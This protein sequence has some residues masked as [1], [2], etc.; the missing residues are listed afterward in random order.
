M[1]FTYFPFSCVK[2]I[3]C[4]QNVKIA[5][6]NK[7]TIM[8]FPYFKRTLTPWPRLESSA[9][10]SD[11]A[12]GRG[13]KEQSSH[14]KQCLP[15]GQA[16]CQAHFTSPLEYSWR[17]CKVSIIPLCPHLTDGETEAQRESKVTVAR[18]HSEQS[19]N[20]SLYQVWIQTP[21]SLQHVPLLLSRGDAENADPWTI[22][23]FN[24]AYFFCDRDLE[25]VLLKRKET[26]IWRE[27]GEI[28]LISSS[29]DIR[30]VSGLSSPHGEPWPVWCWAHTRGRWTHSGASISYSQLLSKFCIIKSRTRT[31]STEESILLL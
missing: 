4:R 15:A 6:H 24:M 23:S 16:L 17:V 22:P 5:Q 8:N 26:H 25:P 31:T 30:L 18:S 9:D 21:C 27:K 28:L 14:F 2:W 19:A 12:A 1:Y 3:K 11:V 29:G 13:F 20:A 10:L 7:K